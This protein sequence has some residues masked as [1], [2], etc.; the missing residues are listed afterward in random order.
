[1][2]IGIGVYAKKSREAVELYCDAFGLELGYHVLNEDGNYFHSELLKDGEP[3]LAVAEANDKDLPN[4]MDLSYV[5][6]V[7]LGY[8]VESRDEFERVF[9]MLRQDGRVVLDPCELPWSPLATIV[10]DKFGVRWYITLPQ[11]R[12]ED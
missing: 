3:F 1:M 8:T 10:M 2:N 12:P 7:E 6:P 11:H 5:N 9:Q 4:G